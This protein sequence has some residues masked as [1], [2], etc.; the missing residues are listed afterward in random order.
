VRLAILSFLPLLRGR[1]VLLHEDNQAVVAVLSHLTSRSPAMMDEL[2]KL[3]ELIDT[4]NISIHAHYIR[5][6]AN[7]WADRLSRDTDMD[8][9]QLNSL[10][11]TYLDSLWAPHSI[12]RFATQGNS[13]ARSFP[14]TTPTGETP[15]PKPWTASIFPTIVGQRR[16]TDAA[17]LG[18][19]SPTSCRSYANPGPKQQSSR[20][21]GLPNNGTNY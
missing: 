9:L 14:A 16:P 13:Q 3:W 8:D 6:A 11:F 17:H 18:H 4:Y 7:V 20:H 2:R 12:D 21:T 15:P 10:I 1:K 5:S 19:S